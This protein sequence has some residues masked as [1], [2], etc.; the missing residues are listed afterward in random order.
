MLT[1]DKQ[2]TAINIEF[3]CSL[4]RQGMHQIII[5]LETPEMRAIEENGDKSQIAKVAR[6][7]ITQQL[8]SGHHQINL[9]TKDDN[10]HALIID[11][12]SLLYA[13]EDDL[14]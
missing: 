14:K 12:K 7:S 3:A 6:E 5:G 9:D 10:P 8:A 4:S 11:G 1:G 2:E 13:L